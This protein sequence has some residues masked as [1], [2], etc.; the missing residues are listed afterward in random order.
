VTKTGITENLEDMHTAGIG[1]VH[2]IPIYGEKG[3][4]A[5]YVTYLSPE[6]MELLKHTIREAKRLGM[7]VDMTNGTGWPFGGPSVSSSDAAK[8]FQVKAIQ[9]TDSA[10]VHDYQKANDQASLIALA[11]YDEK[12]NYTDITS[13]VDSKGHIHWG[14]DPKPMKVYAAFQGPTQQKVKR[15]AP[16]GE[17]LVIDYFS[18]PAI[19]NYM[20]VFE[21]AFKTSEIEKGD[22][23]SFYNDSYEVY[24]ANWTTDFLS[25]F[26]KR[27]G[28]DLLPYL[29]FLADTSDLEIRPR[30]VADYCETISDL[31]Y[32]GFTANWVKKSHEIGMLT[33]NQAHGS[34]GNLLDLYALADIPE[35]ESFG[36]SGFS[37]PGL[38][39]DP[40]FEE[41][42]FGRPNPLTM[43]FASSAANIAGRNLVSSESTTWLGD[44]FKVALSQIKPQIDELFISGINHVFFHGTTYSPKEKP[45]PG[46]LFYASTNYGPSSHF[47]KELPAL[48]GYIANCQTILQNTESD[49]DILLYF[50][51]HE[52]WRKQ[53][54]ELFIRL[55][56]VHKSKDWLQNSSFGNLAQRLWNTGYTFDYISDRMLDG[57]TVE[58][59]TLISGNARYKVIVVPFI[60]HIP[61]GTLKRLKDLAGKGATI[62]FE[63][64]I[65]TDVP[66]MFD[67]EKKRVVAETIKADMLSRSS[68]IRVSINIPETLSE[69]DI[70]AEEMAKKGLE[71]IRKHSGDSTIYFITNLSDQFSEDW[72][73]L[74]TKAKTVTIYDPGIEKRG[75]AAI[76]AKEKGTEIYLQ[77]L[78]G[79]SCIL[80][81]MNEKTD[82]KEWIYQQAEPENSIAIQGNWLLTPTQGA[83][84]LPAPVT[85]DHLGTWTT[86]GEKYQTYSGKVVYS[87][88]F[89][90]P[91]KLLSGNGFLLDLGVVRETARVRINGIDLGLVWCLPN[92]IVVPGG[93]IHK[94]NTIEIEVTNLTF[95]RII[96]LD[97]QNANWKN[98]NEINFVNIRYQPYDAS[99]EKPLDSGLMTYPSLIPLKTKNPK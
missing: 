48:T 59:G 99:N 35:T 3:D 72:I 37:I 97:K 77:L 11:G 53:K 9:I 90:I 94:K 10:N 30:V 42:R 78:P 82:T 92:Q 1:G 61:I 50:P 19:S 34:P 16:G 79:Q 62:I 43:K 22:I 75:N 87:N 31:L 39:Q 41:N 60:Q 2:I 89:D 51:I 70:Y 83:P 65:P 49:N 66:G 71:F 26:R 74:A 69:K 8:V 25:E 95:N 28:Y 63:K 85:A 13:K 47:W 88:T 67:Y 52:V 56:D 6:W 12:G 40:D 44:H 23:R 15:S 76:K 32:N 7:G 24:G 91:A 84:E 73:Q 5:N 36:A 80:T 96:A 64:N 4:E 46:R 14:K 21:D 17:G 20:K 55:F 29:N 58:N 38:R 57:L 45:F 93:I 54:N 98:F 81:C 68:K 18:N 33:R 86:L 27:R